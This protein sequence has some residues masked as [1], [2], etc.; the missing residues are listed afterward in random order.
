M[1]IILLLAGLILLLVGSAWFTGAATV[2]WI[3]IAIF[4]L[5]TAIQVAWFLYVKRPFD[6]F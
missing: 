3:C 5:I 1:Q 4:T 2:G 6:R